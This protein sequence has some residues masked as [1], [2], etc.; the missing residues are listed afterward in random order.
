LESDSQTPR[1]PGTVN[2]DMTPAR[3]SSAPT[4]GSARTASP[5]PLRAR[6]RTPTS[7]PTTTMEASPAL[8]GGPGRP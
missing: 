8:S 2:H 1:L 5:G 6:T 7:T 3:G 4:T